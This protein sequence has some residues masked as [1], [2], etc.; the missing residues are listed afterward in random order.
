MDDE[1]LERLA[2]GEISL[3]L[4]DFD[5]YG[6][7]VRGVRYG[8]TFIALIDLKKCAKCRFMELTNSGYRMVHISV[9]PASCANQHKIQRGG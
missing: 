6:T 3:S 9:T 2:T 7:G 5:S 8:D 1:E 4:V